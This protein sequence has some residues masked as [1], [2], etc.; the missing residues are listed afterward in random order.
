MKNGEPFVG[1]ESAVPMVTNRFLLYD[2]LIFMGCGWFFFSAAVASVWKV[3]SLFFP[4]DVGPGFWT[5]FKSV[6]VLSAGFLVFY[7]I[8]AQLCALL[9]LRNRYYVRYVLN[10]S[11]ISCETKRGAAVDA[12]RQ[13]RSW[14]KFF[15]LRPWGYPEGE[16][17]R[18]GRPKWVEWDKV[19]LA[20]LHPRDRVIT[21]STGFLPVVRLYCPTQEVYSRALELVRDK[22]KEQR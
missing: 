11:G 22:T 20:V 18:W 17:S 4:S 15:S 8:V 2:Y 12:P 9:F 13:A 6:G 19:P 16:M 5:V 14:G 10:G 21:L 3:W 7:F 1:F